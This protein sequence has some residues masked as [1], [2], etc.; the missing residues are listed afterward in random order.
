MLEK[1]KLID[2]SK[3]VTATLRRMKKHIVNEM[4]RINYA[5]EM[6]AE[7]SDMI[8]QTSS[9]AKKVGSKCKKLSSY[10]YLSY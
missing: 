10:P 7:D 6:L 8:S 4:S 5:E 2:T 9:E 3:D 1:A